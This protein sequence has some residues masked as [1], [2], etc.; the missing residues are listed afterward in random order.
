MGWKGTLRSINATT[1]KIERYNKQLDKERQAQE[2]REAVRVYEDYVAQLISIHQVCSPPL[3]WDALAAGP[4]PTPPTRNST[5]EN[6]ALEKLENFAPG[7][8]VKLLGRVP[9]RLDA[10]KAQVEEGRILDEKTFQEASANH[11]KKRESWLAQS[12]LAKR[13]LAGDLAAYTEAWS[14]SERLSSIA[15]LGS[16]ASIET[17]SVT[18]TRITLS[19]NTKDVIPEDQYKYLK[20]GRLSIKPMTKSAY[21]ELYQDHV[22]SAVIRIAR[23]AFNFLPLQFLIV[24]ASGAILNDSTGH[25]EDQPILSVAFPKEAFLKVNYDRIDCSN[26]IEGFSHRMNF[27]KT[28]GFKPITPFEPNDFERPHQMTKSFDLEWIR[29]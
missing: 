4:E 18:D 1:K 27:K 22:C 7:F 28:L 20:S 29:T 21:N 13:V 12:G 2:A 6:K 19:V 15:E 3:N 24:N 23:E 10:L 11:E 9:K 25:M 14:N 16:S 26:C 17:L 8:F 5:H